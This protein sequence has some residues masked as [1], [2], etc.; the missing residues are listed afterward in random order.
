MHLQVGDAVALLQC[1]LEDLQ[2]ADE[3]GQPRQ[4]LLAAAAHPDQQRIPSGRLQDAVD[5]TAEEREDEK[6]TMEK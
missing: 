5:T 1:D 3:G 6:K 2:G 4:A